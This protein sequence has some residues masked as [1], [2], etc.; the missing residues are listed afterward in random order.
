MGLGELIAYFYS[1]YLSLHYPRV[2]IVR[3]IMWIAGLIHLA[4]F[5]FLNQ[6]KSSIVVNVMSF[7]SIIALRLA[8]SS[9]N[10]IFNV[11]IAEVYP[12]TVRHYAFGYFGLTTKLIAILAPPFVQLCEVANISPFIPLSIFFFAGIPTLSKLR[13][14]FGHPLQDNLEEEDNAL[15]QTDLI[16]LLPFI[17]H[18]EQHL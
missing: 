7:S 13:E 17:K 11:Y 8:I 3:G 6:D 2:K 5:A 1:G 12:T 4:F 18:K 15:L 9:G 14:T 16:P 10:C